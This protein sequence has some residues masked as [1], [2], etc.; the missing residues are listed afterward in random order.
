MLL[1]FLKAK[2]KLEYDKRF[3]SEDNLSGVKNVLNF[4]DTEGLYPEFRTITEGVNEAECIIDGKKYLS[5]CSNNYLGLSEKKTVKEAAKKAIDKYGLG[6]GG[7][8]VIAG[9]VDI[10]NELEREIALLTGTEA[11][12]TFPTGYMA[13]VAVFQAVMDPLFFDMPAKSSDGVIFSDEYNHGSIVDGCRLSRAKKVIFKHDDLGDLEEKI[14]SN[15]LPNKL[16]VTEGVF[17]LDGEIINLPKYV[18]I[19]KKYGSKLMIDDAHGV[20]ILGKNGGG[21]PEHHNCASEVDILMGCMDKAFGGTGG[22]LCGKKDLIRLLRIAT[23]SSLLS[24]ALPTGMAGGMIQSVKEIRSAGVERSRIIELAE[25]LKGGLKKSGFKLK[26]RDP[27]PAISLFI[28]DEKKGVEFSRR[29]WNR[30]IFSPIIRWPAVPEGESRFRVLIMA[31]HTE[32]QID[33][34]LFSCQQVG[35]ELKIIG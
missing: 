6:P 4:L 34:F 2:T 10:I 1:N 33:K 11:C 20:G 14:I 9:D 24:S 15:N 21:T 25:K 12:L 17:S 27:I 8:R 18:D 5:F 30:G 13:N 22:F 19:A 35:E 26:E 29:L 28:G 7:S 31:S 3:S 32:E 16:I 23:R